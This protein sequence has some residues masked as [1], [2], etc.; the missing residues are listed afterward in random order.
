MQRRVAAGV[1]GAGHARAL[2]G[3]EDAAAQ[4][5]M[6]PRIVAEGFSVRTLE[7]LVTVGDDDTDPPRPA[8]RRPPPALDDLAA[9]VGPLE[10]RVRSR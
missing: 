4:E 9:P 5:R 10:T 7:E 8:R 6:A 3:M 1:L 2:L